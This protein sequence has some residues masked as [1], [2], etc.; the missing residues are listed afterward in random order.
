MCV[1]ISRKSSA[2]D[3]GYYSTGSP[4]V[5]SSQGTWAEVCQCNG[6]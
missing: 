4:C 1:P 6:L 2:L 5:W 3:V